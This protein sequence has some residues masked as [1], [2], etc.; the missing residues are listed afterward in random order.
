VNYNWNWGIYWQQSP[1][2]TG[3]YAMLLLSGLQWTI[4]TALCA[5]VIAL[6]MGSAIG[7]M[8]TLPSKWANRFAG[9]WIELFR[10]IPIL[11]QL[12][13]WFFVL[14]ELLPKAMGTALKQLPN[15]P[16]YIAVVGLG[17]ATSARVAVQVAAGVKSLPRGQTMAG[18]ALGLSTAQTYQHV[19]LPMAFRIVLPPLTSE[20]LNLIKNTSVALTIGL[21]ELTFR[22]RTM[23]E[24]SFQ[25]F[26][27]FTA[28]T[29]L[30][31][32]LNVLVVF[33]ARALERSVAV[34]GYMGGGK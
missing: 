1:E 4:I 7:V 14:P 2:G 11:V 19:L 17:F 27:A 20:F 23:Q 10:N 8:R 26:E 34:P 29:V 5:W 3:T 28:A 16:F 31:L 33:G 21:L 24:Y 30:Y 22:A 9:A 25:V 12:F 15:A 18:Y 13:L 32:V 6:A